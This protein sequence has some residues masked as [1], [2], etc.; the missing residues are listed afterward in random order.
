MS[1]PISR[2]GFFQTMGS[3][4]AGTVTGQQPLPERAW[5]ILAINWV[6]NDEY[7]FPEGESADHH[8]Y[9][10]EQQAQAACQ[11]LCAAF[12]ADSPQEFQPLWDMY[13]VDPDTATWDD[14]RRDGFPD[15]YYVQELKP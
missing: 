14:L 1:N 13:D 15:P 7:H 9:F 12:F 11:K 6:Y 2:R 8:V 10:D 4:A 3:T 5:I